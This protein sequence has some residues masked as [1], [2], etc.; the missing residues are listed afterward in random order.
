MLSYLYDPSMFIYRWSSN[1]VK[2]VALERENGD[3]DALT[4]TCVLYCMEGE[5]EQ[6]ITK[7]RLNIK[8]NNNE[9]QSKFQ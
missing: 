8:D 2:K 4:P 7:T 5:F 6:T 1:F 3:R 9:L